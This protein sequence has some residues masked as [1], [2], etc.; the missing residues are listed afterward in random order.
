MAILAKLLLFCGPIASVGTKPPP[1]QQDDAATWAFAESV[2]LG[3]DVEPVALHT[4]AAV[5]ALINGATTSL[6][7]AVMYV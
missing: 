5:L 2:P 4:A 3:T 1:R 6:D 7:M